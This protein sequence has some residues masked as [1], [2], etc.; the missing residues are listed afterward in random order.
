MYIHLIYLVFKS[1]PKL[2]KFNISKITLDTNFVLRYE[3]F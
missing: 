3:R 1:S 2:D